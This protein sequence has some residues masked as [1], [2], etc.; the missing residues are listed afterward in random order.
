[1]MTVAC[2]VV[3][4]PASTVET[5]DVPSVLEESS[6]YYTTTLWRAKR[7]SISPPPPLI[8]LSLSLITI[9]FFGT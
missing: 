1:M 2:V 7:E 4:T 3:S 8:G 6:G 5:N 9:G